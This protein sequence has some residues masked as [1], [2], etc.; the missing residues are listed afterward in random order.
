MKP[1]LKKGADLPERMLHMNRKIKFTALALALVTLF[2]AG[3]G[4]GEKKA[5][6]KKVT[7]RMAAALP[8]N[9][10]LVKAMEDLKARAAE[11]SGGSIEIVIYPAGKLYTDKTM[12]DALMQGKIELAL[13]TAGRWAGT[14]PVMD[15]FDVPFLFPSYEKVDEAIDGGVGKILE[16][17]LLK[18]GVRPLIW[19]DYGFVQFAN[20][21]KEIKT[22]DDFEGLK[23]RAYSR[24]SAETIKALGGESATVAAGEVHKEIQKGA[25]DGHTSGSPA[26]R[27]R[28]LYEITKFLTITNHA[29]PEF[30]LAM[31]EKAYEKLSKEQRNILDA[32]A[33]DVRNLIRAGAKAEDLKAV[34]D[35]KAK[36]MDVY[37]VPA[38]EIKA[39]QDAAK[40]VWD[41]FIKENGETG[42][43]LIEICTKG[44]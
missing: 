8:E 42:K 21:K 10:P 11:K 39:W 19:A 40:P 16:E 9:H 33:I 18:K 7:L 4:G 29:S 3:C 14:L 6:D 26:M 27:D 17:E 35:L 37:I 2:A 28:K 44:R 43:K 38:G 30:I 34:E 32:A 5:A 13:N 1:R 41:T 15:I 22:P 20:R 36:G 12:N 25:L 23:L 24:Y 31:N